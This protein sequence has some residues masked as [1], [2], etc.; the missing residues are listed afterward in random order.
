MIYTNDK[1]KHL[2]LTVLKIGAQYLCFIISDKMLLTFIIYKDVSSKIHKYVLVNVISLSLSFS[3]PI[4]I[5]Q[6]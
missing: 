3:L 2:F 1:K 5:Q 4:Y 6:K